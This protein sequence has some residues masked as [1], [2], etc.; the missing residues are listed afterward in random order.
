MPNSQS[1]CIDCLAEIFSEKMKGI[2]DKDLVLN[3]N[4]FIIILNK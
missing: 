2:V 4:Q 3:N 1:V